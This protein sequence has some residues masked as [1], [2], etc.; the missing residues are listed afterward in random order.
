MLR[1]INIGTA[2]LLAVTLTSCSS[3]PASEKDQVQSSSSSVQPGQESNLKLRTSWDG[4]EAR[5][6]SPDAT[7]LRA[8]F[9]SD[10]RVWISGDFAEAFPGYRSAL[11]DTR[12]LSTYDSGGGYDLAYSYSLRL[13]IS[14]ID[15][16]S[17][18]SALG[19]ICTMERLRLPS[20]SDK[21]TESG[22]G[23]VFIHYERVGAVPPAHQR[24]PAVVPSENVFGG[25]RI[26]EIERSWENGDLTKPD[27]RQ[28]CGPM[29][30]PPAS[31]PSRPGWPALAGN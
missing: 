23:M 28:E 9:E 24:G 3:G 11:D 29:D 10:Y 27:P 16:Q 14:R 22:P 25:W 21:I 1:I 26:T 17:D 12:I 19:R 15:A 13:R 4:G 7:F 6:D 18:F 20:P 8:A 31:G 5:I 2:A 30:P